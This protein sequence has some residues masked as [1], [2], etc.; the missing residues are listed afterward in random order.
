MIPAGPLRRAK[1]A[2]PPRR[3][4]SVADGRS[5]ELACQIRLSARARHQGPRFL[6]SDF[7]G[8]Q[9][10]AEQPFALGHC[11]YHRSQCGHNVIEG[12]IDA[13]ERDRAYRALAILIDVKTPGTGLDFAIP[14]QL[15]NDVTRVSYGPIAVPKTDAS[16][17]FDVATPV[18]YF[19]SVCCHAVDPKRSHSMELRLA[20]FG[21]LFGDVGL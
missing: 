16:F 10:V 4:R 20:P 1:I 21:H 2:C 13:G 18:Q 14:H 5:T 12:G 11:F 17:V 19:K 6:H 8:V 7:D 3:E 9:H 15:V